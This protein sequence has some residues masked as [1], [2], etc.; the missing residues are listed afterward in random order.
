MIAGK[1]LHGVQIPENTGNYRVLKTDNADTG[2]R[3]GP[4]IVSFRKKRYEKG[5]IKQRALCTEHHRGEGDQT[6]TEI[7]PDPGRIPYQRN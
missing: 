2:K 1:C 7:Q 5:I 3:T 6:A 4:G